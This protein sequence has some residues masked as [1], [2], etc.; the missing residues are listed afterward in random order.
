MRNHWLIGIA[1]VFVIATIVGAIGMMVSNVTD[2]GPLDILMRPMHETSLLGAIKATVGMIFTPACWD[3]LYQVV[4]WNMPFM[5][6]GWLIIWFIMFI[7]IT[8]AF[9]FSL[10][11]AIIR[12]VS[13]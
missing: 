11:L 7:P 13:S 6:G 2:F 3:A 10:L 1:F 4:T 5:S 12:G 8:I 9:M